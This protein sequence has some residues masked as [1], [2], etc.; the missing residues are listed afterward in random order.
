M[1]QTT[2]HPDEISCE[3]DE[4]VSVV[5]VAPSIKTKVLVADADERWRATVRQFLE[6]HGYAVFEAE[7]A[8]VARSLLADVMPDVVILDVLIPGEDGLAITRAL[9]V[10]ND[11]VV[12]LISELA[13]EIDR[14]VGLEAGADDYIGKPLSLRELLA[15]I[16]AVFRRTARVRD[17][18]EQGEGTRG[19][20]FAGWR[21]DVERRTLRDPAGGAVPLSDGEFALLR[22]FVE[23]PQRVLTRDQLLE[24][25][26]GPDSDAF[27]RAI[28]TQVSRLRRKLRNRSRDDL[29]RTVRSEGYMFA[30]K[31]EAIECQP[32]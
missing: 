9:S 17:V 24:Y 22:S 32:V 12:I 28:D 3:D 5:T 26:R 29:I 20:R 8:Q 25:A 2:A 27:D 31:V 21:L 6:R 7:S 15:R 18:A 16:R 14:V 1:L 23:R 4:S 10:R 19:Y 11:L 30:A 13:S